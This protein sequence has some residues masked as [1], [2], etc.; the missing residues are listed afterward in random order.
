[1]AEPGCGGWGGLTHQ[2]E[3]MSQKNALSRVGQERSLGPTAELSAPCIPG[4]GS[5]IYGGSIDMGWGVL[6]P[7]HASESPGGLIKPTWSGP[8]PR[9]SDSAGLG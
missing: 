4:G 6:S 7:E 3:E 8:T 2:A 1:M 9:A 5:A